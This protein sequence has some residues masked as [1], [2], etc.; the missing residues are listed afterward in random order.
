MADR[1]AVTLMP[2]LAGL[3]AGVTVTVSRTGLPEFTVDGVERPV[4]LR[5]VVLLP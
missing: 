2:V 3:L 1:L 4:A 5:L